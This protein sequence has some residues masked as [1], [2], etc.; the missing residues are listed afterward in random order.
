MCMY[1]HVKSR[2]QLLTFSALTQDI[3]VLFRVFS[4]FSNI[5]FWFG[6]KIGRDNASKTLSRINN[7]SSLIPSF[8]FLPAI[9]AFFIIT[10]LSQSLQNRL[11]P[12]SFKTTFYTCGRKISE[13]LTILLKVSSHVCKARICWKANLASKSSCA[14]WSRE[15]IF[16][17]SVSLTGSGH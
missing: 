2:K 3:P 5:F 7:T 14:H 9:L 12:R 1:R 10:L 8:F 4:K 15:N 17:I 11:N 13:Q 16:F 6:G